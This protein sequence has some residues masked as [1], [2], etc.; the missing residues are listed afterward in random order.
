M[1]NKTTW[2]NAII[3]EHVIIFLMV[4][5]NRYNPVEKEIRLKI[6]KDEYYQLQHL[7]RQSLKQFLSKF[8]FKIK[9]FGLKLLKSSAVKKLELS[10]LD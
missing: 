3:L 4:A 5:M 10:K 8:I 9:C 7:E 6:D 1:Q 2:K